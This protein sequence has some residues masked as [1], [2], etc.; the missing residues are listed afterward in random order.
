V[1]IIRSVFEKKSDDEETRV[2]LLYLN[3]QNN[4]RLLVN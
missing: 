4:A 1:T 2:F 3:L